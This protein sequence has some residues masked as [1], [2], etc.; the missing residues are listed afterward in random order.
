MDEMRA[1]WSTAYINELPD[2]A[3]LYIEPGGTKDSDGK[4]TPRDLRH[5]PY[6]DEGG[7]VDLPHL[8]NALARIPQSDLP[9]SV[10]DAA[11][12]KAQK[13]L[14]QHTTRSVA[15]YEARSSE[16]WD[17]VR[18]TVAEEGTGLTMEGPMALF[19][20]PSRLLSS[21]DLGGNVRALRELAKHGGSTFR[22]VIEPLAFHKSL[23]ETPDIVL[24]YQHDERS[25]PLGRTKAGT[26]RLIEEPTQ[27]RT[28]A[29]LPDNEWGRPVRDAVKRGDIGGISFR[30]GQVVDKWGREKLDDGY[31]GPVRH[32]QEI[33]MRREVSLVTFPGYETSAVVRTLSET[34]DLEYGDLADAF[35]ALS[36][37]DGTITTEQRDLIMAAINAKTDE[38]F[39]GPRLAKARERL[40]A[41]A[42]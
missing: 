2:S 33:K 27:V 9:Q 4:T 22:E 19:G 34:T 11:T 41:L 23:S 7:A 20:R 32:L 8:S 17:E 29:D 30:M 37:P 12:A 10:K 28:Q 3:F 36:D 25:L 5:F 24:H 13:L 42:S 38:P 14:D 18:F 21:A 26:L 39:V 35:R 15:E 40:A 16:D 1:V 31:D 6:R